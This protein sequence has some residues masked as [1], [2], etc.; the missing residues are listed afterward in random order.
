MKRILSWDWKA[1]PHEIITDFIMV[2][3]DQGYIGNIIAIADTGSDDYAIVLSDE[4]MTQEEAEVY[5]FDSLYAP[6]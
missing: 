3:K 2:I 5:Y 4:P 6:A 1:Q